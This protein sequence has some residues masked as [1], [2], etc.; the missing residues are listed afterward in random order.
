MITL[1]A[2]RAVGSKVPGAGDARDAPGK[3]ASTLWG[4]KGT[5]AFDTDT[6]R[7]FREVCDSDELLCATRVVNLLGGI[8][9]EWLAGKPLR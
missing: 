7:L 1:L 3:M 4:E 6:S 8:G 5:R 2:S 9:L